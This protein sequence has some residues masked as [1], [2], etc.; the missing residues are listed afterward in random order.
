MSSRYSLIDRGYRT[1]QSVLLQ[2]LTA[3]SS[4]DI[5]FTYE[6]DVAHQD[7]I[8]DGN[9]GMALPVGVAMPSHSPGGSLP[10]H[11]C[12]HRKER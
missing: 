5:P 10:P 11:I 6:S 1:Q 7:I 4:R 9:G 8:E 12:S 3:K 2:A